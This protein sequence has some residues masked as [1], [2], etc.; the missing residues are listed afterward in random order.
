VLDAFA[1]RLTGYKVN[2]KT[3]EVPADWKPDKELLRDMVA[4]RIAEFA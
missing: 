3:I 4:A 2:K 1:P